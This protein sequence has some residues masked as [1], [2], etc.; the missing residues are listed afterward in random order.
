MVIVLFGV[1][2][3]GKSTV[4]KLLADKLNWKFIDA[5][6]H[7]PVN[8]IEKMRQGLALDDGDRKPWL[9]HLKAMIT[10]DLPHGN[11]ILACSALKQAY[12]DLLG[13]DQKQTL[14]V[15]LD[16]SFATIHTRLQARSHA[17]MNNDLLR[18]QFD[19]LERPT[20][21]LTVDISIEPEIMCNKIITELNL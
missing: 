9:L 13:I 11:T 12:R 17:F 7:H 5:D 16:G 20:T 18:S 3:C 6:D 19:T 2:G 15:L 4:G 10:T 8:N 21:G 14:S 1:S